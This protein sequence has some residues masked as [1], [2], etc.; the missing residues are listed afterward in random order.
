MRKLWF[1]RRAVSTMIG[2][3]IVLVLFLTGLVAMIIITQGYDVYQST[4]DRMQAKNSDRF[5]EQLQAV[6]PGIAAIAPGTTTCTGGPQCTIYAMTVS[7][8]AISSQIARIYI[9]ST[10]GQCHGLC[11][12]DPA[13][14]PTAYTFRA[15]DGYVN[16][17]E[18]FHNI[19]FWLPTSVNLPRSCI[20]AGLTVDYGC[21]SVT[22]VTSR[23]KIFSFQYPYPVAGPGQSQAAEGG[24]GI[25]IG[26]VVYTYQ[27]PLIAYS[28]HD[29]PTPV[30]PIGGTN[31]YWK[32]PTGEYI[33][34][35]VKL[36]QDVCKPGGPCNDVYL[37][38][39]SIFELF[40]FDSP[41][42]VNKFYVIAPITPQLCAWFQSQDP[43]QPSDIV[44]DPDYGYYSGGN[45]GDPGNSGTGIIPYAPCNQPPSNYASCPDRYMIPVPNGTQQAA[46]QRGDA[47]VVAFSMDATNVC[48]YPPN[49]CNAKAGKITSSWSG[50]S[51]TTFL[52]L[53][54][55]WDD[56]SGKYTFGVTLP[57]VA[58][59]TVDSNNPT[60]PG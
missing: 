24:T 23:G 41:A 3:I 36:Q 51:V 55:I 47:V 8:L 19:V 21:N 27:K 2:G 5:S 31:G 44:C 54:Y 48:P 14:A 60:C 20:V 25:Y 26:P 9:N 16:S 50:N 57:F 38:A 37:T 11:V 15:S 1:R 29:N 10:T 52:G 42:N 53:T 49:N 40:R 35:Y 28:T 34:F 46:K 12:L 7:N 33:I 6:A 43:E 4:L 13:Q 59:C 17:G 58:M 32:V 45:T 39:Q 18:F 30:I 22:I 56:G